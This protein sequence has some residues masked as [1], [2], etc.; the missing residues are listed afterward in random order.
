MAVTIQVPQP[1]DLITAS[2]MKLL[3]DQL[4]GLDKRV[5]ALEGVVPG[6]GG[7]LVIINLS[8]SDLNIGDELR[9]FGVNFGLP[10]EN[11]VTF[12]GSNA[13]TQFKAGSNDTLLILDVPPLSFLGDSQIYQVA[14]SDP[15][16][17]DQKPLTV[18]KPQATVPSG[19]L[20]VGID[21]FPPGNINVPASGFQNFTFQFHI[22]A[23]T[24]MDETYNVTPTFPD[25]WNA[26][27]VTSMSDPTPRKQFPGGP[28]PP[29]WQI[30]IAKP[31]SDQVATT[32]QVFVQL[33]IPS[34]APVA[35]GGHVGLKVA[36]VRNPNFLFANP[37][38][39]DF[40]LNAP[41]PN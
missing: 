24:N 21:Q 23:R 12:N 25:G 34:T 22:E 26:I 7:N 32:V 30:Q 28:T 18:H 38:S 6:S 15:R 41:A 31:A 16:G 40:A 27:L 10:S 11:V 4:A 13:V 20:Q 9:I 37:F 1:G 29:P 39:V 33:S 36:S 2:F 3:I 14:V 5:S 35:A 17:F 19:T 8:A